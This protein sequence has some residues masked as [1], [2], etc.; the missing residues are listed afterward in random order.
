MKFTQY[1]KLLS[2]LK[3]KLPIS[4]KVIVRR[5]KL[6][7]GSDGDC[8]AVRGKFLVRISNKLSDGM[9]METLIHELG[10]CLAYNRHG[11]EHGIEWGKAYSLVYRE[12][13]KWNELPD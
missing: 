12:F 1:R 7:Q 9:A 3:V 5:M 10:H 6:P 13:L 2:Y 4:R 8:S 11:N